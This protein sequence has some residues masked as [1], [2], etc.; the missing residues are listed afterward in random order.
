MTRHVRPPGVNDPGFPRNASIVHAQALTCLGHG[1]SLWPALQ[2]GRSGLQ[3]AA[4]AFPHTQ[5]ID[6]GG[7]V[8]VIAGIQG[9]ERVPRIL[10]MAFESIV[11]AMFFQS[12]L[13]IG[14]S[15][16]GDLTG[17]DAGN[18]LAAMRRHLARHWPRDRVQPPTS[19]L[20]SACSSGTDALIMACQAVRLGAADIVAV[21]AFDSLEA[22][23]LIQHIALGTQSAECARPFDAA[24]S[25][26]SFGE[27]C[28]LVIVASDRGLATLRAPS[29]GHVAGFGMSSDAYDI[30]APHPQGMHAARAI[31]AAVRGTSPGALGYINAHGSGTT[32][33]D[34]A[35][36]AALHFALGPAV[37]QIGLSSTKGALGHSLG[38]TGLVEAVVTLD[39]LRHRAYPPTAGLRQL[40]GSLNLR[41]L[42]HSAK[43]EV[44]HRYG[45]SV[46]FG[47][48]GIN[49]AILLE[50]A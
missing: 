14:A 7:M 24:R 30:A 2:T 42:Q 49:S 20:S 40:D 10:Q 6:Q 18:P 36:C 31:S 29:L 47:F 41:V 15:S 11:P 1:P 48:G 21:L 3:P 17:D 27:A 9:A 34:Q 25:G 44:E 13:I 19:M 46:T 39:A 26:T 33:N 28:A 45:M 35:E 37:S 38:A 43:A 5:G 50:A 4:A 22:G 8:G 23:K 32:L 12:D 16:L